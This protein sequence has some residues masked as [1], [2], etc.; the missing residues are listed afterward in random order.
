VSPIYRDLLS[1]P[2]LLFTLTAAAC[3]R[4]V[5]HFYALTDRRSK[6]QGYSTTQEGMSLAA[7]PLN[8]PGP[9]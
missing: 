9:P 6:Q 4:R 7:L 3:M 5:L 1:S 2:I 8:F